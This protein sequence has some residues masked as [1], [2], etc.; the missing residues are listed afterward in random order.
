MKRG[1][2]LDS[3]VVYYVMIVISVLNMIAYISVMDVVAILS[4]IVAGIVMY[5]IYPNPSIAMFVALIVAAGFRTQFI[6]GLAVQ[7][8]KKS[9]PATVPFSLD[10]NH[11]EGLTQA[12]TN[13]MQNQQNLSKMAKNLE[14]MIKQTKELLK[15]LPEGFLEKAMKNFNNPK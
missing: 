12:S 5:F 14:P 2:S 6:E 3:K 1:G 15:N 8:K 10:G 7:K 11:L 9:K 13:L 4:Y